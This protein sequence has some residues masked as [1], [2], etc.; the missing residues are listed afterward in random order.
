MQAAFQ[1]F[2]T[3]GG[4]KG[5]ASLRIIGRRYLQQNRLHMQPIFVT[6]PYLICRGDGITFEPSEREKVTEF[7]QCNSTEARD[8]HC[9]LTPC[10]YLQAD[11][12]LQVPTRAKFDTRC[13]RN[14]QSVSGTVGRN[15]ISVFEPDRLGNER[16]PAEQRIFEP[17]DLW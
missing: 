5:A 3:V 16:I 10:V 1:E 14:R 4:Q 7:F 17:F 9:S 15:R 13:L 12:S 8:E 11:M 6:S 2:F